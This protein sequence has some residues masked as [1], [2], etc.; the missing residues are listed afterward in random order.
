MNPHILF[1]DDEIPM[2]ETLSLC[3][4]KKGFAVT[5]A[6][7]MTE[8]KRLAETVAATLFI[9]DIGI[10]DENGLDLLVYF[11]EKYPKVPVIMFTGLGADPA[12][13]EEAISL[14][15]SACLCKTDSLNDLLKEVQQLIPA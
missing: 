9:L 8:A 4:R 2:R 13:K 15:A 12:V 5:A 1:V 10:A 11:K 3:F 14:G 6:A 7:N